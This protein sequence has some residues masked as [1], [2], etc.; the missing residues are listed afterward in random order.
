MNVTFLSVRDKQDYAH[1]EMDQLEERLPCVVFWVQVKQMTS[2]VGGVT[3]TP[4]LHADNVII[5][6]KRH[7]PGSASPH[8]PA[9][10]NSLWLG[11]RASLHSSM[12]LHLHVQPI[13][14][15]S[16]DH[17]GYLLGILSLLCLF[18]R[19]LSE[20]EEEEEEEEYL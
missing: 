13:G 5:I 17:S 18:V 10:L 15:L 16:L 3:F 11:L 7:V 19:A 4:S 8:S 9:L 14:C 6:S 20:E 12:S 1:T 2:E